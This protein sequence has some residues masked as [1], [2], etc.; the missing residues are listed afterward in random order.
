MRNFLSISLLATAAS[1]VFVSTPTFHTERIAFR[2]PTFNAPIERSDAR[3]ENNILDE[4]GDLRFFVPR[5]D[6]QAP[7]PIRR[8]MT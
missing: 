7:C 6:R 2:T 4:R 8:P 1:L 3:L 5:C